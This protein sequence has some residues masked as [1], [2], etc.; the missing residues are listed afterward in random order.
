M[1]YVPPL[2]PSLDA[3]I[4]ICYNPATVTGGS[5][6]KIIYHKT[7]TKLRF[8]RGFKDVVFCIRFFITVKILDKDLI[9]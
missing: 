1:N 6:D 7:N 8:N 3:L 9:S 5:D 4:A 2:L